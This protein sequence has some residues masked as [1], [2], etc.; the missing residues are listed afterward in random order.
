MRVP[1]MKK[2]N[3]WGDFAFAL[4]IKL[5]FGALLGGVA[6]ILVGALGRRHG[7]IALLA[8]DETRPVVLWILAWCIG[9]AIWAAFT[10][11]RWQLPWYED[12]K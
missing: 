11:P 10:I 12:D 7:L 3:K 5:F 1:E 9:G 6:G 8:R 4:S 2:P